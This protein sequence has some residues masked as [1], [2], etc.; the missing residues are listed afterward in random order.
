MSTPGEPRFRGQNESMSSYAE[1][2]ASA[3]HKIGRQEG[4]KLALEWLLVL[5][6]SSTRAQAVGELQ[7]LIERLK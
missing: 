1:R 6:A 2:W 5:P 7:K 4:A 3:A